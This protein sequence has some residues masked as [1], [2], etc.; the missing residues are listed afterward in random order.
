MQAKPTQATAIQIGNP[1]SAPR[2]M[3]A[4]EEMNGIVEQASEQE[5]SDA[6]ARADRTGMYTCPHTAVALAVLEKLVTRGVIPKNERVV[7]VSTA[8]G[9]KFTRVQGRLSRRH[10]PGRAL[11]HGQPAR[12]AAAQ[13]R[14]RDGRDFQ[15]L[16]LSIWA[17]PVLERRATAGV[18]GRSASS[19][20]RAPGKRGLRPRGGPNGCGVRAGLKRAFTDMGVRAARAPG[21]STWSTERAW[22]PEQSPASTISLKR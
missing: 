16:R 4:L 21:W 20:R 2:A 8:N 9:L 18:L 12:D 10:D 19:A 7:C 6:A 11:H 15:A 5:L 3:V 13:I 14:R 17:A 1:V 22:P